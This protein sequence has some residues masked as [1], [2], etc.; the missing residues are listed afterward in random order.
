LVISCGQNDSGS[1]TDGISSSQHRIFVT[2]NTFQGNFGSISQANILCNTAA[3]S[4]GLELS[5]QAILSE[6]LSSA[7]NSLSLIGSVYTFDETG[8]K[9]LITE[10]GVDL[11]DNNNVSFVNPINRDEFGDVVSGDVWTGTNDSGNSH[12]DN[13]SSWSSD[14]SS[15]RYGEVG[16]ISFGE[17]LERGSKNCSSYAH[18]Y[19]ISL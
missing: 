8:M 11:W 1:S 2:S 7:T 9:N 13:C 17:W 18:L 4:A 12:S 6:S 5:Y 19:C 15:G 16:A 10:S 3:S 14:S